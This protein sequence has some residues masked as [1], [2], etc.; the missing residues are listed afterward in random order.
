M[1]NDLESDNLQREEIL[2][3]SQK[4]PISKLSLPY[5]KTDFNILS[6]SVSKKFIFIITGNAELLLID[7]TTNEPNNQAFSII[8]ETSQGNFKERLTKIWTDREGNHSIVSFN[9]KIFYF[10]SSFLKNLKELSIFKDIEICAIAFD[11]TNVDEKNSGRFLACDIN[12]NIYECRVIVQQTQTDKNDNFEIVERKKAVSK[13]IFMNWDDEDE[14]EIYEPKKNKNDDRIYGIS[15]MKSTKPEI[16][17]NDNYCY[18]MIVT[19]TKLYQFIG[20]GKKSFKQTFS[21]CNENPILFND[22]C[23]YFPS[24]KSKKSEFDTNLQVLYKG[25]ERFYQFGWKTETGFCFGNFNYS[26]YLPY[27]VKKFTVVPFAKIDNQGNKVNRAEPISITHTHNHIFILYNDSLTIIS[28]LTSNII[29]TKYLDKDYKGI[30]YNEFSSDG[31][32]IILY[33]KNEIYKM[34]LKEENDDIWQDYLEVGDY[35]NLQKCCENNSKLL[36]RIN[37]IMAEEEFE[38]ND[39]NNSVSKYLLSDENFE[40]VCLKYLMKNQIK[41]LNLYLKLN[42]DKNVKIKQEYNLECNLIST[43]IIVLFLNDF[44]KERNSALKEFRQ[45]IREKRKYLT[46]GNIIYELLRKYGK[47]DELIEFA[48]IMGDY[49]NVILYYINEGKIELAL[50]NLDQF[51]LFSS[52]DTNTL[53]RLKN[54]FIDN[55][56]LFFKKNPKTSINI[57]RKRF[58]NVNMGAIIQAIISTTDKDTDFWKN[59][60]LLELKNKSTSNLKISKKE[61]DSHEILNYLKS[62]ID[63]PKLEEENNIHNL[64]IYYLSK[65]KVNQEAIIDYLKKPFISAKKPLFKFDYA[66]KLFKNNPPAYA[67]VLALMGKYSDAVKVALENKSSDCLKIAKFIASNAPEKLRKKLWIDIFSNNNQNQFQEAIKIIEESKV[68][69]I[70]DVLPHITDT[71]KIEEF[72][73]QINE[74][75]NNFEKDIQKLKDDINEYNN[76]A[77]N[78]KNDIIKVKNKSMEVQFSSCRCE[79]CQENIKEDKDIYIFPCGHMFD[80]NCIRNCLLEYETTGLESIHDKN[81]K[82]DDLFFKLGYSKKKLFI[83]T[84]GDS[85]EKENEEKKQQEEQ[86]NISNS[87]F[88]KFKLNMDFTGVKKQEFNDDIKRK[89][90]LENNLYELLSEQ[91]VF[92]GD[93]MVDSIQNSICKQDSLQNNGDRFRLRLRIS[94]GWDFI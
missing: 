56:R 36:K 83:D 71:I 8:S 55:C 46:D 54:I 15:F 91:C 28:K 84:K 77:E 23:K 59:D 20:P 41:I 87:I 73:T 82:I 64:Y 65:T 81:V 86:Q 14:D 49:E 31:G 62:L 88:N 75:I 39:Y 37:R 17:E 57:L 35:P 51:T 63:K 42:L 68:L 48:S 76:T 45:Q 5:R 11:E 44:K 52:Q 33:S 92:C 27:E 22:S 61:D 94:S 93:Y 3:K 40:I 18:I 90:K 89:E 85:E 12:N 24:I 19:K 47:M 1:I 26:S 72:R 53:E 58:T 29:Y 50:E 16:N 66:K 7:N 78:I 60:I 2:I 79:I 6:V 70:E 4:F 30:I 34:S 32:N 25:S 9:G 13:L 43:F 21:K 69:Q 10:N 38:K 67:L 80:A 74:C